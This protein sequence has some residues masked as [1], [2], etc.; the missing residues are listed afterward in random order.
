MNVTVAIPFR[1]GQVD[2]EVAF[3]YTREYL[4]KLLP[5]ARH[6]VVDTDHKPYNRS[7]GRNEAVRQAKSGIVIVCDADSMPEKEPIEEAIEAASDGV[8][9]IPYTVFTGLS[10]EQTMRVLLQD[11]PFNG[12]KPQMI[13]TSSVGGCMVID[14]DAYWAAGGQDEGFVHWG[15]EDVA[16][17]AACE[18]LLG[19]TV[20]HSGILYGLWHPSEMNRKA[21]HYRQM[22]ERQNRYR[23]LRRKPEAMRK[24]VFGDQK[25]G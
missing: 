12:G 7:A 13:S 14:C 18:A 16:F 25:A 24:L 21:P 6:I 22:I 10:R 9:H 4:R 17:W 11:A 5:T 3:D 20:R 19:P 8:L 23:A 2:R 1:G 15:G